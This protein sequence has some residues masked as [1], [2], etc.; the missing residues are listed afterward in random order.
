MEAQEFIQQ[1]VAAA[2]G[3]ASEM[4]RL[5]PRKANKY[6][7]KLFSLGTALKGDSKLQEEV[8]PWLMDN[9]DL[10]TSNWA[11][12][13]ALGYDFRVE[14]AITRL[15][16]LARCD[17]PEI[18]ATVQTTLSLWR[19]GALVFPWDDEKTKREKEARFDEEHF[20]DNWG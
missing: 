15:K 18:Q 12:A 17:I 16:S 4:E 20:F 1:F 8:L 11:N 2:K 9:D 3:Q 19:M 7:D 13:F 10:N 5:K 14:K 6:A